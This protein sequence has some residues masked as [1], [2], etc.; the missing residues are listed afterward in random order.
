M[1]AH[2]R[3]LIDNNLCSKLRMKITTSYKCDCRIKGLGVSLKL[4]EAFKFL[5][6]LLKVRTKNWIEAYLRR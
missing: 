6:L 3:K 4:I 5:I 2:T 1:G